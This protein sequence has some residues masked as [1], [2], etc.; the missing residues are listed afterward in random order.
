MAEP[1][2]PRLFI[3]LLLR[4]GCLP[5]VLFG[6]LCWLAKFVNACVMCFLSSI[7]LFN[8]NSYTKKQGQI[9]KE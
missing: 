2:V 1:S 7:F 6:L 5:F 4:V 3:F 9:S 8:I